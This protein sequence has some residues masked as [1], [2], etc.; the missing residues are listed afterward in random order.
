MK[1]KFFIDSSIFF[2]TFDP[3]NTEKLRISNELIK[4]ALV[5]HN[6]C[7]SYQIIEEFVEIATKKFAVPLTTSDS[8]KYFE[9]V[10]APLCEVFVSFDLF[11]NTFELAERWRIGFGDALKIAAAIQANCTVLYSEDFPI[12]QKIQNVLIVNPFQKTKSSAK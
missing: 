9:K 6:G 7:I 2:C 10:L 3:T 11:Q 5:N 8:K 4:S 12:Y 1:D